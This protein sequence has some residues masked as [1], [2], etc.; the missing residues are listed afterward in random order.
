MTSPGKSHCAHCIGALVWRHR[1][2]ECLDGCWEVKKKGGYRD[3]THETNA[4][5][6]STFYAS[7]DDTR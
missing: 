7:E 4:H 3:V 6:T 5:D 1:A 2:T